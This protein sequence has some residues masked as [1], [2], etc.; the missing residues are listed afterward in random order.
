MRITTWNLNGLRAAIRKGFAG[1][2]D[3]IAPDV[4]LLQ[5]I[6]VTPE[7]LPPEWRQ[8]TG[9]FVHWH[10][11]EKKGYSG[12]A[13]WSREPISVLET[14]TTAR[15][16]DV[17]GRVLTVETGGVSLSS[18]Y[19]PS[20]SSG[21]ERQAV[22]DDWMLRF[23]RW[24]D[25]KRKSGPFLFGGD[26]NIAHTERDIFYA[27]SNSRTSGFLPH[28][29]EWFG[30]LLKS[31]WHDLVREQEGDVDGP[32]SWWSNRGK[33]REL[34]RGWRIDY[35]L[36]NAEM[37]SRVATTQIDREAGLAVSDHAPVSVEIS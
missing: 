32:Y 36:A 6:R 19:L 3:R 4:L 35:L 26:L 37:T 8:P 31:G 7:Q 28:E 23:R 33:A 21:P 2:L 12:T 1:H 18:V 16:R 11:A 13:V 30:K 9:W 29:R 15:D 5:E 27:K 17:E 20:G 34:D 14:G 10:P 22:K 25:R 24:A